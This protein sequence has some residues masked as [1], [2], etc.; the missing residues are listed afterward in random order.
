MYNYNNNISIFNKVDN[1]YKS[2]STDNNI[3]PT[4]NVK[5]NIDFSQTQDF[6]LVNSNLCSNTYLINLYYFL[7]IPG[8]LVLII[9]IYLIIKY[10]KLNMNKVSVNDYGGNF[11]LASEIEIED[12]EE[13]DQL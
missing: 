11:E 6:S 12:E 1:I 5:Y 10:I 4:K 3:I 13:D 2:S 9:L 8:V 7:I